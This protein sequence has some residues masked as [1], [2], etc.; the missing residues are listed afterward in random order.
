[1]MDS[2]A[3]LAANDPTLQAARENQPEIADQEMIAPRQRQKRP[4]RRSAKSQPVNVSGSAS[5][6]HTTKP[7]I[8]TREIA[9]LAAQVFGG[10][11]LLLALW[12]EAPEVAMT[13]QEAQAIAKPAARILARSLWFN[14]VYA[15]LMKTAG[16]DKDMIALL[17]AIGAYSWRVAPL[18][19]DKLNEKGG[20][21]GVI[22]G[23]V[24]GVRERK[25]Q[26]DEQK[27]ARLNVRNARQ[28]VSRFQRNERSERRERTAGHDGETGSVRSDSGG[29]ASE[30][31]ATG[32]EYTWPT[33]IGGYAAIVADPLETGVVRPD[34]GGI[35]PLAR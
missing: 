3:S 6:S 30:S 1:M 5:T 28:R 13:P 18:V 9:R 11:T 31:G 29:P 25:A 8:P 19:G 34:S 32:G 16:K 26:S 14:Q 24:A 15:W 10:S 7:A 35:R 20:L 2:L 23:T 33:I 22:L 4:N 17:I 12:L 21:N 27:A